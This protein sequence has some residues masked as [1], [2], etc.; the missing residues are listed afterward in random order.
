[1]Q[2]IDKISIENNLNV[3]ELVHELREG[4]ST[5]PIVPNRLHYSIENSN[6]HN[7]NTLLIMPAWNPGKQLE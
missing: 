7:E 4:F 5:P 1:M 2:Y 3:V 6:K